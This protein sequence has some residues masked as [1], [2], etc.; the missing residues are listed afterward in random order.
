MPDQ[1]ES[2]MCYHSAEPRHPRMQ[3]YSEKILDR[4]SIKE[5]MIGYKP[6]EF[7]PMSKE[8]AYKHTES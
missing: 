3:V 7:L 2:S 4:V 6:A 1:D 8:S 5:V